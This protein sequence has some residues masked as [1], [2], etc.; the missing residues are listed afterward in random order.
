MGLLP[1]LLFLPTLQEPSLKDL[2]D[3]Q[4][5]PLRAEQQADGSY[6]SL[7]D[8]ANVVLGMAL[9]PRAY[10]EDDGPFVRDAVLFLLQDNPPANPQEARAMALALEAVAAQRYAA[11]IQALR[12]DLRLV[13]M[14]KEVNPA[15][16]LL[17]LR[18]KA[19]LSV[20]AQAIAQAGLALRRSRA[21]TSSLAPSD[22]QLRHAYTAGARFLLAQRGKSGVWEIFGKPEPG[23]S[24]LCARALLGNED[25]DSHEAAFATL[26]WL[27]SIQKEDGSIHGGSLPVYSTSV[28]I[29]AL[30]T[31]RRP[32]DRG[33]IAR[34]VGF[35][36][37]I[38]TDESE[39]YSESDRY[40][41][42]I[43][44]GGDLRPDL[45]NLH[46]ALQALH[47]TGTEGTD[48]AFQRAMVFLQRVQN[49]SES[50]P[51]TWHRIG[52]DAPVRAGNDGGGTYMPGDSPAG[53]DTAADGSL[54]ARSYGSMT[55]ALL[56]CYLFA[57]LERE[58]PRLQ[59]AHAWISRH[60]TLEVNPGFDSLRDPRA[61]FQGYYYYLL[62][63]ADAL[64][65]LNE[66]TITAADGTRHHWR[67]ELRHK[68]LQLQK[69]DGSW[70]NQDAP[71]W[72][73]GNPVLCT[74]YALNA[75]QATN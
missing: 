64:A 48:P 40:Y 2:F 70:L 14:P 23:I 1:L 33:S 31:G 5:G 67:N 28:A 38:Q 55:Y 73:E 26:D 62:S 27:T 3:A 52:D 63:V 39:G 54:T 74:A 13:P 75:L 61:A 30:A 66:E 35:L 41:G 9:S 53:Y 58:D 59:A 25:K 65:M 29:R 45:S 50:N 37:Q 49:R 4:L 57:G 15:S 18:P 16:F 43:G 36:R 6:G 24:A 60:W 68:L 42:G 7:L 44:Y 71:R 69:E 32:Q 11:K 8:T 51:Q 22:E 21:D 72:W 20:R 47:E 10:R 12:Q 56:K 19:P 17:A 34:A 46:L